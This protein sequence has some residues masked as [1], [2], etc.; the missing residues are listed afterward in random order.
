MSYS[1]KHMLGP[2]TVLVSTGDWG[3][4]IP[5]NI[6]WSKVVKKEDGY[7]EYFGDQFLEEGDEVIETLV[8]E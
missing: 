1:G 7:F 2:Q 8:I 6:A 4:F 3:R 5:M